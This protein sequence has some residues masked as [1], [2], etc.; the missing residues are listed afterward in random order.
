MLLPIH[1][2]AGALAIV[3]GAIALS[4]KK[5]GTVHRRSGML[6]VYAMLVMGISASILGFRNSPAD[7][8]VMA[9]NPPLIRSGAQTA[10][11]GAQLAGPE[12]DTPPQIRKPAARE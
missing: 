4:V 3:L 9:G 10:G 11:R 1:V 12:G 7:G 6:F 2:V 8:N 5:G